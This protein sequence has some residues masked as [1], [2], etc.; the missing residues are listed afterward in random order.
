[1]R[2][3]SCPTLRSVSLVSSRP[4]V[5]DGR[6]LLAVAGRC[7]V[8]S[9]RLRTAASTPLAAAGLKALL[10]CRSPV[11]GRCCQ[12]SC[13]DAPMGLFLERAGGRCFRGYWADKPHSVHRDRSRSPG[14]TRVHPVYRPRS[15]LEDGA[16][17]PRLIRR[18][19]WES[20]SPGRTSPPRSKGA[21]RVGSAQAAWRR[22]ASSRA[23][24]CEAACCT[25]TAH[26]RFLFPLSHKHALPARLASAART[27]RVRGGDASRNDA[28]SV[29]P[30]T[31]SPGRPAASS[32][33]SRGESGLPAQDGRASR[34]CV[35]SPGVC[36]VKDQGGIV[37]VAPISPGWTPR[38]SGG[39]A[40]RPG[41]VS[42]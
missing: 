15:D 12:R 39:E 4:V 41:P 22:R 14:R 34:T 24:C 13:P 9:L 16:A 29:G 7:A 26:N 5:T 25:G 21:G 28:A 19:L 32:R 3:R 11:A 27:A 40:E 38:S 2:P 30:T 23:V 8:S 6:Y 20:A 18:I 35:P 37:E 1:M 42:R 10:R 31:S 36:Y 17:G 33:G